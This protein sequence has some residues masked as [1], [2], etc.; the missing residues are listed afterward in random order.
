MP[1][2]DV[3]EAVGEDAEEAGREVEVCLCRE[4]VVAWGFA[5]PDTADGPPDF[6]H[7]EGA[8]FQLPPLGVVEDLGEAV[9]FGQGVR[10]Q[11]VLGGRVLLEEAVLGGLEHGGW[12]V[13]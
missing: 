11:C 10:V 6:V 2:D 7:G 4:A 12:V 3:P 1:R 13:C 5:L 8:L 9:N